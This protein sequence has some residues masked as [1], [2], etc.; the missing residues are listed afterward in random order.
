MGSTNLNS[1]LSPGP[2]TH[3]AMLYYLYWRNWECWA[4]ILS[5][6]ATMIGSYNRNKTTGVVATWPLIWLVVS[7]I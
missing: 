3:M 2:L 5:L 6:Q 7:T 1:S 4:A